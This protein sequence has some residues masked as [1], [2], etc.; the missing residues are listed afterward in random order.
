V[1]EYLKVI[2][3]VSP[4][5]RKEMAEMCSLSLES[6]SSILKDF[7]EEG[8]IDVDAKNITILKKNELELISRVA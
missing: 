6:L 2:R 5:S 4:C 3:F 7:K 1:I 8:I